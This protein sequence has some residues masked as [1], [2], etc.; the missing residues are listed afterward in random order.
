MARVCMIVSYV[1]GYEPRDGLQCEW[2]HDDEWT[3]H[4]VLFMFEDVAVPY[5]FI[6]TCPRA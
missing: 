6:A 2:L 5:V 4:V 1:A 3:H